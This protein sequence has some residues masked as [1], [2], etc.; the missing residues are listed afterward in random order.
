MRYHHG[1]HLVSELKQLA[2]KVG[3]G[4]RCF[5]RHGCGSVRTVRSEEKRKK[6]V[7]CTVESKKESRAPK[8]N[9]QLGSR[10]T[11]PCRLQSIDVRRG[12]VCTD[13]TMAGHSEAGTP[14]RFEPSRPYDRKQQRK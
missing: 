9:R 7:K 8:S 12:A 1:I 14:C 11:C 6:Y 4:S 2:A 5:E 3:D 13:V 10:F